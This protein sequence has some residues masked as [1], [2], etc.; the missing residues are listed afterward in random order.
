MG[1]LRTGG[2]LILFFDFLVTEQSELRL[3]KNFQTWSVAERSEFIKN[4]EQRS[5]RCFKHHSQPPDRP[6]RVNDVHALVT[7]FSSLKTKKI[8]ARSVAL[9]D[10]LRHNSVCTGVGI[11]VNMGSGTL[12]GRIEM[13]RLST[14]TIGLSHFQR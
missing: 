5:C 12:P 4:K 2:S 10:W 1:V 8:P 11:F 3:K 6:R 7:N 13:G 9:S 14:V